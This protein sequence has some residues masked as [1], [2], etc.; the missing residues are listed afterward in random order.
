MLRIILGILKLIGILLAVLLFLIVGILLIVL[1]TPVR[2]RGCIEKTEGK[3]RADI[4]ISWLF[5]FISVAYSFDLLK[6]QQNLMIRICGI[7]LQSILAF[8]KNV[9]GALQK[10]KSGREKKQAK[11]AKQTKAAQ[12]DSSEK[13]QSAAGQKDLKQIQQ[14]QENDSEQIKRDGKLEIEN[15]PTDSANPADAMAQTKSVESKPDPEEE[16]Q[17]KKK[18]S[19][20]ERLRTLLSSFWS[21]LK[22]LYDILNDKVHGLERLAQKIAAVP[23]KINSIQMKLSGYLALIEKY[24]AKEVLGEVLHEVHMLLKHYLPR[25]IKGYLHFGTGDPAMTGKLT[26]L[27]YMVLPVKAAD[28]R[29]EPEFTE[30][31]FE[32]ELTLSGRIRP[33]HVLRMGWHLFRNKKLMRLIKKI[34]TLR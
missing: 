12:A 9:S 1:L 6:K 5:H 29:I 18:V 23:E 34:R 8:M 28:L 17:Y 19:I 26:G 14:K 32:T 10:R 31:V 25:K 16:L 24:K 2:Y 22:Q 30:P 4:R 21:R 20:P 15:N 27:I 33:C 3:A 11:T 13:K 7:S